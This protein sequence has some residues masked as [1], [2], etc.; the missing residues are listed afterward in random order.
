[1]HAVPPEGRLLASGGIVNA[2]GRLAL[3]WRAASPG[4]AVGRRVHGLELR[5]GELGELTAWL[6]PMPFQERAALRGLEPE[7]ADVIVP[8]AIILDELLAMSGY[9]AFTVSRTSVREGVLWREA[10]KLGRQ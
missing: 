6:E 1:M 3:E 8:G 10:Q 2:L 5:R 7:R 9:P 4:T